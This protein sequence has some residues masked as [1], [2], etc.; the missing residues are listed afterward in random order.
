MSVWSVVD[1]WEEIV[2]DTNDQLTST[3]ALSHSG[4]QAYSLH[5]GSIYVYDLSSGQMIRQFGARIRVAAFS[6]ATQRVWTADEGGNLR[7]WDTKTGEVIQGFT[8]NLEGIYQVA[9][10]ADGTKGV[11]ASHDGKLRVWNLPPSSPAEN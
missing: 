5:S 10:S 11:S 2:F 3:V 7:L 9:L 6:P 1:D 8:A 4:D